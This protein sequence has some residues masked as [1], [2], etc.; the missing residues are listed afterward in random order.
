MPIPFLAFGIIALCGGLGIG[1]T[2]K[3]GVDQKDANDTNARANRICDR[4]TEEIESSRKKSGEA[5]TALGEQKV[6]VL[7]HSIAS[8]VENFGKLKNVELIKDSAGLTEY[9]TFKIDEQGVAELKQLSEM[10]S[11]LAGGLA[12]GGALGALAAFGA[13]SGVM[14]LGSCATTGTAITTLSGIAA[15]NATLAFLGGGAKTIGGLGIAGGAGVLGGL[16]AA[17]ALAVMGFVMGAKASKN[18]D[19]AYSNLAEAKKYQEEMKAARV[20]CNGIRMRATMF[21]RLLLKLDVV[22]E[23]MVVRME[24]IIRLRGSDVKLYTEDEKKEIAMCLSVAGAVKAILDTSIL[25]ENGN[26]TPESEQLIEPTQITIVKYSPWVTKEDQAKEISLA[27]KYQH[28]E[29]LFMQGKLKEAY[30]LLVQLSDAGYARA[31]AP[32]IIICSDGFPGKYPC[33]DEMVKYSTRGCQAGDAV[34]AIQTAISSRRDPA[35]REKLVAQYLSEVQELV[36]KG[37][38]F[39]TYTLAMYYLSI[40]NSENHF[41]MAVQCFR[42]TA[43]KFYRTGQSLAQRYYRGEGVEKNSKIAA[44]WA[45]DAAKCEEYASPCNLLGDIA[46]DNGEYGLAIDW[47]LK[48]IHRGYDACWKKLGN[49]YQT[50]KDIHRVLETTYQECEK[51]A[52]Q[53]DRI[54]QYY[55]GLC[56]MYGVGTP[57]DTTAS[58]YWLRLA[59]SKGWDPASRVLAQVSV[60]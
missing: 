12:G 41:E 40:E 25:T 38:I 22:F 10:A 33:K 30:P 36:N 16:I 57:C 60:V 15:K 44:K 6:Y 11:S 56:C 42:R 31:N 47:Y 18:K 24:Q 52:K 51:V 23:P 50:G 55:T 34:A 37:D 54:G 9:Q 48:A 53:D 17:P 21:E 27:P 13:Y 19:D 46:C 3:A 45:E 2:I 28:A 7:N 4:A 43:G 49:I 26:L 32:L 29:A 20:L 1:K 35:T 59:A 8:F 58:S 39:A 14:A 5:I